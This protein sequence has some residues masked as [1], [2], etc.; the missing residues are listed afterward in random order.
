M[1]KL[2][3]TLGRA[4]LCC[5]AM[6]VAT[7][8]AS[9]QTPKKGGILNFAVVSSPPSYDCH[10]EITFGAVH[11]LAPHYSLLL[12]IDGANFPKVAGDLAE[13]WTASP[14]SMTFT[15]RLHKNVKFH[16]GTP[17]TAADV[18]ASYERIIRPP[19]GVL[20]V[21]KSY[22]AD[23][24]D[25]ETPDDHTVVFKMKAPIAGVL[26]LLASPFN[27]IYSAAKLKAGGNYPAKEVMGSGA[28][29]FVEHV[30]GSHWVGKR[31]DAY[32]KPGFPY[33]DGFKAYF[34]KSTAVIPGLLGNQ[35]DA[36]FRFITPPERNTLMEKFG[37]KAVVHEMP[38]LAGNI[39]IFNTKKKPFDDIRVRQALSMAVDRWTGGENI[40]KISS[41]RFVGGVSRPGSAMAIPE[42]DLVKLPGFSKNA[43]AARAEAKRLLKEAGVENLE[44]K[45]LNRA[46]IES[47]TTGGIYLIDQWR[48]IGLKATHEQLESKLYFDAFSTGNFDVGMEFISDYLDDP[49]Q[50]FVKFLSK[51]LT[52]LGYSGHEDTKIDELYQ[53]QQRILDP[54]ERTKVV[55]ELDAYVLK[56]AYSVPY[57]WTQRIVVMPKKVQG[58]H[59]TPTHYLSQDLVGV[60]LDQ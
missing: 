19:Q 3:G 57:L 22:Y 52:P 45:F 32:F 7:P 6:L 8:I 55:R 37:D 56:T 14:D 33:L 38:L 43:E 25:I 48:R 35:F 58:W 28:F 18:K 42:A 31:F 20:S 39:F 23:F 10:A 60:W 21:R 13:S 49:T 34:V 36:E 16:D 15:F 5:T 29:Q 27:C 17:L 26:D 4:A 50:N 54:V 11:P 9:A 47:Y 40:G 1:R 51:K 46:G 12:K 41:L 30:Q 24:G 53:K 59:M 2:L 44:F